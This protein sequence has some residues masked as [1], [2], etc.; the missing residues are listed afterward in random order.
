MLRASLIGPGG[1]KF[2]Y[3]NLLKLPKAKFYKQIEEIAK[4][5]KEWD[6]LITK[7]KVVKKQDSL[8]L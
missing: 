8:T 3:F 1:I 2:Y 5:L 6:A 7:L 4:V